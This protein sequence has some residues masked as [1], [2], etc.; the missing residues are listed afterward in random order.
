[1]LDGRRDRR[2]SGLRRT[3]SGLGTLFSVLLLAQLVWKHVMV[4]CFFRRPIPKSIREPRLISILTP[5]VSGDPTLPDMLEH[6]LRVRSRYPLEFLYLVDDDDPEGQRICKELIARYGAQQSH[7]GRSARMQ[8]V[9][10]PGASENPKMIKLLAGIP[11][12]HGDVICVLDDDTL[13]PDDGLERCLPFLDQPRVGLAFGLPYYTSFG[14]FWSALISTFVNGN[15]LLTYIPY[16]VVSDPFTINGMF[17]VLRREVYDAI[18]GFEGLKRFVSDDFAIGNHIRNSGYQLA[19]TPLLHGITTTVRDAPHYFSLMHRWMV[20][21]RESLIRHLGAKQ[22]AIIAALGLGPALF[23][24]ALLIGL[25]VR[26]SRRRALF[27]TGYFGY[28]LAIWA[29]INAAY[30]RRAS[31]WRF[32]WLVPLM[33]IVFPF[34]VLVALLSPKRINWRGRVMIIERGGTFRYGQTTRD[35]KKSS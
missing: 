35:V 19:Q 28:S 9:A 24:L 29:H 32:A 34:Q 18:G 5:V 10:G 23:P 11:N 12:T 14:S 33:Q 22:R 26:P 31:P 1:M 30:L 17:Y 4:V 27:A 7:S 2:G 15:S 20:Y 16:T 13:L 6:N 8:V 3:L 25:F 21:P